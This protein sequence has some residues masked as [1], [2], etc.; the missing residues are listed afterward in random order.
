MGVS[1]HLPLSLGWPVGLSLMLH[2]S[3]ALTR[4]L[5]MRGWPVVPC[6]L[7]LPPLGCGRSFTRWPSSPVNATCLKG[8]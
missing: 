4:L 6:P 8:S 7:A 2:Y 3:E 5:R 1:P